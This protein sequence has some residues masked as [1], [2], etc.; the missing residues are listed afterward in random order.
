[1]KKF[2]LI[3]IIL[4]SFAAGAEESILPKGNK[5]PIE[6][7][8]DSLEVFQEQKKAIFKGNVVAKQD[9]MTV[10]SE[11]MTVYYAGG[12]T[13]SNSISKI[14]LNGNVFLTS[15]TESAK[16]QNGVFD[17]KNNQVTL[18]GDVTLTRDKNILKGSRLDYDIKS[19]HSKMV[20]G[21]T[22]NQD[23]SATQSGRVK[24]LFTP[25]NKQ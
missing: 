5:G 24:V 14:D 12:D 17:V 8:A 20:G 18:T 15:P 10:R 3:G 7:N 21:V 11:V 1:M 2:F 22:Q 25:E 19:G 13:S 4:F 9:T 23:G 6:I 16:A